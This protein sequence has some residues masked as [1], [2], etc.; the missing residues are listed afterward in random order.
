MK[1]LSSV[2]LSSL[3]TRLIAPMSLAS[4]LV[5]SSGCQEPEPTSYLIP[6]E[7]RDAKIEKPAAATTA[8]SATSA[9]APTGNA[10][11]RILPGMQEAA[12]Q[13]GGIDYEVPQGW[14]DVA[15]SGLRKANLFA[16]EGA[17]QA[18]LTVLTFPGDVGGR[19]ANINRWRQQIGLEA[20]TSDELPQFAT[21]YQISDHRGLYIRLEGEEQ[22]ILGGLLPFHGSTWFFKFQG[23]TATV[24]ENEAQMKAFLDSVQL[25]DNHH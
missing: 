23:P 2:Y 9:G 1:M 7:D 5:L 21:G 18:E 12:D 8:P 25:V 24:L 17:E 15:P 10:N 4:A 19:L 14:R 16:G 13:A 20:I 3:I 22:S 11:M 6:K